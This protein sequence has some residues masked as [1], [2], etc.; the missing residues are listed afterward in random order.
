M[1]WATEARRNRSDASFLRYS[2]PVRCFGGV[3]DVCWSNVIDATVL[4]LRLL[5]S[6]QSRLT[7]SSPH[8]HTVSLVESHTAV[9]STPWCVAPSALLVLGRVR[10]LTVSLLAQLFFSFFKTLVGKRVTVELKVSLSRIGDKRSSLT[11]PDNA[12]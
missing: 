12:E 2:V 6:C 1:S 7:H 3:T 4:S 9:A 10:L 11:L 8:R 5:R